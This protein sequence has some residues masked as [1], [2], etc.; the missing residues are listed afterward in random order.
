MV[1]MPVRAFPG[2]S[3]TVVLPV[4]AEALVSSSGGQE[5]GWKITWL[6]WVWQ[7]CSQPGP[8]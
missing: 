8:G 1:E 7:H 5:M 4:L 6:T 2:S 3:A